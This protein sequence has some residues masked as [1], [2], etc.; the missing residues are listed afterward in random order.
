MKKLKFNLLHPRHWFL[1]YQSAQMHLQ[2]PK[3]WPANLKYGF[4]NNP[5]GCQP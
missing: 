2:A 4:S 5:K 1:N 3:D